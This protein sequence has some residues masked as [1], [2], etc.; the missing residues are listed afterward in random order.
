VDLPVGCF[1]SVQCWNSS[2]GSVGPGPTASEANGKV[3]NANYAI[4]L[5]HFRLTELEFLELKPRSFCFSSSPDNSYT[6]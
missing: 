4:I 3:R 6:H 5:P 2:F 1:G